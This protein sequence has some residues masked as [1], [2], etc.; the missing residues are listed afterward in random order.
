MYTYSYSV[1]KEYLIFAFCVLREQNNRI[2]VK[3]NFND[4]ISHLN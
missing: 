2:M 1:T 4:Q 3:L